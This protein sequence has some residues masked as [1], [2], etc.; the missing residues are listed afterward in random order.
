MSEE[1]DLYFRQ[2]PVGEMANL[3]AVNLGTGKTAVAITA[4]R[5]HTCA[6]L[7]DRTVKCWGGKA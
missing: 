3:A 4:G 2:Q 1:S 5:E 7:N 6:L